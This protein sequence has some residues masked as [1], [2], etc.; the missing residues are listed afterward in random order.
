[1][2]KKLLDLTKSCWSLTDGPALVSNVIKEIWVFLNE[3][4]SDDGWVY[5]CKIVRQACWIRL[6]MGGIPWR[7]PQIIWKL[8]IKSGVD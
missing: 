7:L 8:F 3:C 2:C 1:M 6:E 4:L 5:I